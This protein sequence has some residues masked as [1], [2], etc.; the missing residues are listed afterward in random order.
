AVILSEP[1]AEFLLRWK[2]SFVEFDPS[3]YGWHAVVVPGLIAGKSPE[4]LHIE[5]ESSFFF[6]MP[7]DPEHA[8]WASTWKR[9]LRVL[10]REAAFRLAVIGRNALTR[11]GPCHPFPSELHWFQSR[12][13][14]FRRLTGS[15]SIHLWE[16]MWW[17]PYLSRL[18]PESLLRDD[19]NFSCLLR[20]VLG[21]GPLLRG[22]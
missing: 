16:R 3:R 15:Y 6:P 22:G 18:T 4:L 17:A 2:E 11:S 7:R 8:L 9:Y 14:L 5:P 13:K 21:D 1:N 19:D 12:K 10:P 20:Q